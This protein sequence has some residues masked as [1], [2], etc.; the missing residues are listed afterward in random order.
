MAEWL[1]EQGIGEER[2]IL[3]DGGDVRAARLRWPGGLEAGLV[4]DAVLA[5]REAGS[6]RGTARFADGALA[7][8]SGLPRD[9]SEGAAIRLMVVRAA[10]DETGRFKLAQ[11]KP[12]DAELRPA[13]SLAEA[14]DAQIVA[15]FPPGLWD[16]LLIEAAA[17]KIAFDGG[18]LTVSLTPAMT[19]IDVD[20]ALP[21][22]PLAL[23]AAKAAAVTIGRMDLAGSIG[24][25]FPTL[26]DKADRRAVDEAL[27][28]ALE[29]WPHERTAMNGFGFVQLVSRL[30][31]PSIL[32]RVQQD[33]AGAFARLLLRRA[34]RVTEA[35][36][37]QLQ[38]S[39]E[40]RARISAEWQDELGRRTGRQIRWSDNPPSRADQIGVQ[41]VPL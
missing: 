20:G 29:D 13:P 25:D 18:E 6:A 40:V 35:G 4:E 36:A 16:D 22:R 26:T 23:A 38:A 14:L 27:A 7:L 1:V 41:A 19:V 10:L 34:E 24:I 31:R 11:A 37:L 30:N 12:T 8:I 21:P 15:S 28:A 17:G 5:R 3:L 33:P 39:R 2:A 9:S 32:A